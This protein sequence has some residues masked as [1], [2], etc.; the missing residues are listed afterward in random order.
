MGPKES[1][2]SVPRV[3]PRGRNAVDRETVAASQR[4]RLMEAMREL[5]AREGIAAV[6]IAQLV[7]RAGVAKPTFYDHFESKT[8]CFI[9]VFDDCAQQLIDAV[10]AA[11][12]LDASTEERIAQGIGAFVDFFTEDDDRARILLIE[13]AAAGPESVRRLDA[14]HEMYADFYISL[15]EE[16][17]VNDPSIPP[18]SR[19]RAHSIVGALN[20][21]VANVLRNGSS[22]KVAE[23]REELIDSVTLL[24]VGH[25]A[26]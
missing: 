2:E 16:T 11:L 15:R 23:L 5:A 9:A 4:G 17:R 22:A 14:A 13:S 3:L 20:E 24:A 19:T 6:T 25:H 1:T 10:A 7:A 18:I 12:E 8:E 21:P 26:G